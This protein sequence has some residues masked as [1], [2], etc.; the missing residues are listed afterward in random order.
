MTHFGI[1]CP[2]STGHLN[3][4]TTLGYELKQRGHR[5]SVIGIE[6]A[7]GKVE[8]AGLEFQAIGA[9][10]FPPGATIDLFTKLGNLSGLKAVQYTLS[11]IAK[12]ADTV[13]RDAPEAVRTAG[14]EALLVDQAAPEGGTV[15]E[16]L[17]LPFISFC[18]ALMLNREL[19]VPPF[20]TTWNY[21]QPSQGGV[22][23][24]K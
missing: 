9:S 14:I 24:R 20:I 3:P 8:A 21:D 15:A 2:A 4:M 22:S 5:V 11:W 23:L 12:T 13:L 6:D 10:D 16:H 18:N 1:I 19:S 7:R 17:N